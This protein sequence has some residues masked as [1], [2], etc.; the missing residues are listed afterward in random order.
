MRT[1]VFNNTVLRDGHQSMAATRMRTSQ[2]LPAAEVLD[3]MGFG[4]LETWGGASIDACLRFLGE[5]PFDRVR[6][7]GGVIRNT[8]QGMLLRGQNIVQYEC[9]PDDVVE[10]FVMASVKAGVGVF[11]IFDALN[12]A[13][14]VSTAIA[15]VK[16]AGGHARG[17]V[18]Y[19]TSPVHTPEA[20]AA[21][22]C[23][24][25]EMGCASL[26]IKDMSGVITPRAAADLVTTMVRSTGLPVTLHS[27][28]TAGLAASSYLAA[29]DAGAE[30]I[31]TS[32]S[33][34]AN[35]TS[36]PDTLRMLALMEGHPRQPRV[37]RTKLAELREYLTGVY[38]ELSDFTSHA[39]EVVE[40]DTLVYQVPG[41]MLSNF[42]VQLRE[43]KM[44]TRA[45]EVL[46]E[47][48]RVRQALGWPPLV[49][50]ISQIVGTQAML[51][52]KFGPWKNFS[53]QAMNI[54]LGSYG[55]TPGPVDKDVLA[56]A[57][58]TMKRSAV[59]ARP[60]DLLEPRMPTLQ[61]TLRGKGLPDDDESCVLLAMFPREF[62]KLH[63]PPA[64]AAAPGAGTPPAATAPGAN[65]A[66]AHAAGSGKVERLTLSIAGR[67]ETVLIEELS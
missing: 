40:S 46:A 32:I 18:C 67:R 21:Y 43:L 39:N 7:L 57:E 47:I 22:A 26:A 37:D 17:E 24:L 66:A 45:A 63:A 30:A 61:A 13:R 12:D 29:A 28:D 51:N 53:P 4:M 36:Q 20:F 56:L 58:K 8:P 52:V 9:F 14:N 64:A 23:E 6:R 41:G 38:K 59:T 65:R 19:T 3:T 44:D 2:M 10:A 1:L 55:R 31:E 15:A 34:F 16:R 35:G 60:A 11:R 42:R 27:H 25:K 54:A 33:P 50:P 5:Q 49:T 48:P 62:E